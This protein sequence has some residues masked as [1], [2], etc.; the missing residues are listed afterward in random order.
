MTILMVFVLILAILSWT[1]SSRYEWS[2]PLEWQAYIGAW[3]E[4]LSNKSQSLY[5]VWELGPNGEMEKRFWHLQRALSELQK[6]YELPLWIEVRIYPD[7]S[8]EQKERY[9]A[10]LQRRFPKIMI[11]E[12]PL[13]VRVAMDEK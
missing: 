7:L 5:F 2:I 12:G 1:V 6:K 8:P 11:D 10:C 3:K 13:N 4:R 9:I